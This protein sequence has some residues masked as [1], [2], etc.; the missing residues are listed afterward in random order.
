MRHISRK[1]DIVTF[2]DVHLFTLRKV[3]ELLMSGMCRNNEVYELGVA[4]VEREDEG[5]HGHTCPVEDCPPSFIH[6]PGN[7]ASCTSSIRTG[8]TTEIGKNCLLC[9]DPKHL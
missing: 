1:Y 5:L 8:P 4:S 3:F 2:V 6:H 9:R 7:T